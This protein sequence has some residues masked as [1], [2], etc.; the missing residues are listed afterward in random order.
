MKEKQLIITFG[1]ENGSFK[2]LL[3]GNDEVFY[4]NGLADLVNQVKK[5]NIDYLMEKPVYTQITKEDREILEGIRN[6]LVKDDL[7]YRV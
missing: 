3:M 6:R 4:T 1:D 5:V 2:Y 7:E